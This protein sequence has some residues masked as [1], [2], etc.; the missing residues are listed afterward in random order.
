[1][2]KKPSIHFII[3]GGTIDS[4]YDG[5]KD[6]AVPLPHSSIPAFIKSLKL[7]DDIKF[8]EICMKDSRALTRNDVNKITAT[9]QKSSQKAIIITHGTYT[10]PD[11]ARFLKAN[12]KRKDQVIIF[13]GSMIPLTGFAPSDAPF[14][15]GYAMAKIEELKPGIYVAMNGRIF[16]PEEVAKLL[17]EGRFISVF[18][19]KKIN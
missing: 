9:I 12:L 8:T 15:L 19:D 10:M 3:T 13:T 11:T 18:C 16:S 1:M 4:F 6:T 14:S 5:T 2:T 17:D 7:Y